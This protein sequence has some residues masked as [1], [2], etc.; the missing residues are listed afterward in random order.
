MKAYV[1]K[2]HNRWVV[3]LPIMLLSDKGPFNDGYS[4]HRFIKFENAIWFAQDE[5]RKV[6]IHAR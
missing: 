3:R 2:R 4:V 5:M 6:S 1:E